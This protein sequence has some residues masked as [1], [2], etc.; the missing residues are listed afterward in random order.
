MQK[1]IRAG[2]AADLKSAYEQA[3]WL[4]DRTRQLEIAKANQHR[5]KDVVGQANRAR[6]AAVSV[7]G[8]SP[9][10]VKRDQSKMTLRETL[11]A[12]YNGDLD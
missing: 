3:A 5:V 9:G 4:H 1:L 12:A 7:N 10:P 8:N 6:Q 2:A 11:E